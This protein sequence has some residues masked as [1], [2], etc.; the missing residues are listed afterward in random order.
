MESHCVHIVIASV[1]TQRVCP[2]LTLKASP[3]G[4]Q[5]QPKALNHLCKQD[6]Q[7]DSMY[8]V[9]QGGQW[10]TGLGA[11]SVVMAAVKPRRR[12]VHWGRIFVNWH[13][14][15]QGW[16]KTELPQSPGHFRPYLCSWLCEMDFLST[17]LIPLF[18][19]SPGRASST[20][21]DAGIASKRLLDG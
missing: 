18:S 1:L 10:N 17:Q 14:C 20:V 12:M 6:S 4:C 2:C 19:G 5:Q 15:S 13:G 21:S 16:V 7:G 9:N 8:W 3:P 11:M